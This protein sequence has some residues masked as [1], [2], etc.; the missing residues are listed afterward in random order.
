MS[1]GNKDGLVI[2][3]HIMGMI[4][5]GGML[6]ILKTIL[7]YASKDHWSSVAV[8]SCVGGTLLMIL[9]FAFLIYAPAKLSFLAPL[10]M[11]AGKALGQ[12]GK[13]KLDGDDNTK[14][15]DPPRGNP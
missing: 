13:D 7:E 6:W 4:M 12:I 14:P 5:F 8:I 9:F 11:G 1:K 10:S 2:L 3:K 15:T